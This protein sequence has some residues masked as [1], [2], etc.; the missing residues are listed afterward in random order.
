MSDIDSGNPATSSEERIAKSE[1]RDALQRY[2]RGLD[3]RDLNMALSAFHVDSV[4]VHGHFSG[5]GHEWVRFVLSQPTVDRIGIGDSDPD[6]D[7]VESQQHHLTNQMIEIHG[8]LAYSETYFLEYTMSIRGGQRF[9]TSVGGRYVE[10]YA[11]RSGNWRIAM[12][13]AV[14]DWDSV[15]PIISRFPG[16]EA[17]PK[18]TRDRTDPSYWSGSAGDVFP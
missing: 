13:Y 11:F 18:G 1:I 10:C 12:R 7:V 14:R 2:A 15:A 4:A 5:S 9:L 8:D 16:W 17:A 6:L 3:R